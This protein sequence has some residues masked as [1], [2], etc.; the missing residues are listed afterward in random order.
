MINI[1]QGR[2]VRLR[3]LRGEDAEIIVTLPHDTQAEAFSYRMNFP[4]ERNME[5]ERD[6][7][8]SAVSRTM[9]E[10]SGWCRLAIETIESRRWV[11][12]VGLHSVNRRWRFGDI[13]IVIAPPSEWGKGYGGEAMLLLM[14]Y[15]FNELDFQRIGLGV[16][17]P[18][19]R[20]V[21]LYRSL[22]FVEEGRLRRKYYYKGRYHDEILMSMLREEFTEQHH[23]FIEYLY[24]DR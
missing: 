15:A 21:A 4:T 18:N 2:L 13:N 23:E 8:G 12:T 16:F 7:I 3:S 17:E 11:G 22:G 1:W 5:F 6:S 10:E 19:E 24:S 20:A 9:D 14:N